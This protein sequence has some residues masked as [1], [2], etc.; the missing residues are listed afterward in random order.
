MSKTVLLVLCG[1]GVFLVLFLCLVS[2]FV[3]R[4]VGTLMNSLLGVGLLIASNMLGA[5]F[6]VAVNL[7]TVLISVILGLPGITA[8]FLLK[9]ILNI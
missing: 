1:A 3:R 9:L 5:S 2:R 6:A 8:L 7:P 4:L